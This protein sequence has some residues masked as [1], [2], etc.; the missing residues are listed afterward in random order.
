MTQTKKRS[1]HAFSHHR[2]MWE[3]HLWG[4]D[5]VRSRKK[6]QKRKKEV[7]IG[8]KPKKRKRKTT[9]EKL[10]YLGVGQ[11]YYWH[12][13]PLSFDG[14]CE[15]THN[16]PTEI[17]CFAPLPTAGIWS[18]KSSPAARRRKLLKKFF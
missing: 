11:A 14:T 1:P 10:I 15:K 3:F 7:V 5:Y 13:F 18:L 8:E 2:H 16:T 9:Y 6:N 12:L 17:A 4:S